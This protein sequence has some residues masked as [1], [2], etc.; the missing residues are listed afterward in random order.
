M[1]KMTGGCL[2]GQVRYSTDAESAMVA[3]CHCKNC[4]KQTGA[5]S[6]VVIAVPRSALTI[7]G[8][9]TV[10]QDTGDSGQIVDRK[11][12]PEC[13]SPIVSE[14]VIAPDIAFIKG[15]TLDDTSWLDP[16]VNIY[17]ASAQNW[18]LY[19]EGAQKFEKMPR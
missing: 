7:Q 6:S 9:L 4:Q 8:Q 3:V 12:C 15:G 2:C 14:A 18:T 19:P 13:G 1:P 11:F 17:C 10:Y 5:A 16:K